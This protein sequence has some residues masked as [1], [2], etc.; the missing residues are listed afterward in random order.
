M[1]TLPTAPDASATDVTLNKIETNL[2][3]GQPADITQTQW[4]VERLHELVDQVARLQMNLGD[5]LLSLAGS[6]ELAA[7]ISADPE[8][9]AEIRQGIDGA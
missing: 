3:A 7:A 8:L 9:A 5:E 6:G 1:S 4:L 2:A